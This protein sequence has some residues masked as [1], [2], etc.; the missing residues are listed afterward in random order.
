M[1]ASLQQRG[2]PDV[3]VSEFS[4][5][6]MKT[7]SEN[8]LMSCKTLTLPDNCAPKHVHVASDMFYKH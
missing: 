4:R 3:D 5:T 2:H 8:V 7:C 1:W 6:S